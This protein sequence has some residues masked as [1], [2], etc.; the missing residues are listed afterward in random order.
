MQLA[1]QHHTGARVL[2]CGLLN[3]LLFAA[4]HAGSAR[5]CA[6]GSSV[7]AQLAPR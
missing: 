6:L 2:V 7:L 3:A 5:L 1:A 4:L